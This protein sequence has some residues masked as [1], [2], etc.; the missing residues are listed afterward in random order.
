MEQHQKPKTTHRTPNPEPKVQAQIF[1]PTHQ[2]LKTETCHKCKQEIAN[3][4]EL[5]HI[6]QGRKK[7]T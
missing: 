3:P 7:M 5:I 1:V 4:K 2:P 6:C